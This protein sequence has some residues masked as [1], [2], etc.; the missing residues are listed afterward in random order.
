MVLCDAQ[1][2]SLIEATYE[3]VVSITL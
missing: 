1:Y 3:A 2:D